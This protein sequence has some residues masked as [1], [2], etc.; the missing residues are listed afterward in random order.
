MNEPV[1][2]KY[3][4]AFRARLGLVEFI[5]NQAQRTIKVQKERICSEF[6]LRYRDEGR[7]YLLGQTSS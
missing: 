6:S 2:M 1:H 7:D 3:F 5:T 4:L